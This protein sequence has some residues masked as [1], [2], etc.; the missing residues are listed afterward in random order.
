YALICKRQKGIE[1]I[2]IT[3]FHEACPHENGGTSFMGM[4]DVGA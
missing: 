3:R 4:T 1:C 2:P